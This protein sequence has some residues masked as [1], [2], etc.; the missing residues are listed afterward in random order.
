M[1]SIFSRPASGAP[2]ESGVRQLNPSSLF[3]ADGN[4]NFRVLWEDGERVFCRG[5][6]HAGGDLPGVLAVLRAVEH[7]VPAT[8]DR[9][10]HECGLK[11]ELY[12]TW[13]VRSLQLARGGENRLPRAS[14]IELAWR[15]PRDKGQSRKG[16]AS[17]CSNLCP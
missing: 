2:L 3:S 10:A 12:R 6:R 9:L 8:F 7:P 16:Q 13:A 1:S 5:G 17:P 11:D 14:S 4:N 15:G